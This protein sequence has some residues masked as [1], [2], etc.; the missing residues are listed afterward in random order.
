VIVTRSQ[1]AAIDMIGRMPAGSLSYIEQA[2][3]Q[4]G[5]FT[6]LFQNEDAAIYILKQR[7]AQ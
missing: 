7:A 1:K 3:V 6:A 5:K 4:S 2:L